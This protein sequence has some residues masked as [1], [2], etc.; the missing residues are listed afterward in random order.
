MTSLQIDTAKDKGL[1]SLNQKEFNSD[2]TSTD[3]DVG[4]KIVFE[5]LIF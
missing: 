5:E 1:N 4:I 2:F 3:Y